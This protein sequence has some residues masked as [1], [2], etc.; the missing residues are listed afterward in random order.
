MFLN[1]DPPAR[2]VCIQFGTGPGIPI[3]GVGTIVLHVQS[4]LS[5]DIYTVHIQGAYYVPV[6]PMNILSVA[7]VL[8]IDG[9]AIFDSRDGPSHIRWHTESGDVRQ[10]M[11]WRR[12]LPYID[13]CFTSVE[14][15]SIRRVM[16]QGLGHDLVHS[17][18]GHMGLAKLKHLVAEGYLA[19]ANILAHE[20]FA[21]SACEAANAK[22]GPYPCQQDLAATQANHTLHTDLLH[23]PV[24][25]VDGMQY[26]LVVL[27]EYTRYA[28][29]AL[30]KRKSDAAVNL[31][32]IM[33]RGYVLHGLRVKH[34]R[35]DCGGEFQNTV[36]RIAKDE[37]GIA[38]QYVPANCHQ[39]NGLVERLNGT[40]GGSIRVV[41]EKAHLPPEMWGE[42]AVYAVH[43]YNLTPHS[44]LLER[45]A[46]SAIPHKLYI[47]DSADRMQRLYQQLVPFGICCSIIK[48][49]EKPAQVKKLDN[50]SVPGLIV[51]LGPST[52]QYRVLALNP[53]THYNVHIVRHVVINAQ[54]YAE[55][56]A[57][58][59]I[60]EAMKRYV[61][62]QTL[63]VLCAESVTHVVVP[64]NVTSTPLYGPCA[65]AMPTQALSR[66]SMCAEPEIKVIEEQNEEQEALDYEE[67]VTNEAYDSSINRAET[68]QGV[69]P[70]MQRLSL[71]DYA[72]LCELRRAWFKKATD[73]KVSFTE[74]AVHVNVVMQSDQVADAQSN[75]GEPGGLNSI[76]A[77][78]WHMQDVQLW[79]VDV[80]NPTFKQAINGPDKGRWIEAFEKELASL[81]ELDVYELVER[82]P[83]ANVMKGK[84]ICKIKR[85]A[86]GHIERFKCRYVGCGY[87]QQEGVDY[88]EHQ[89]WAPTGQHA[90]L[91]V[92][93]VHAAANMLQIRHIDISTAFLHGELNENV[94]VE[95]PPIMNDGSNRVWRLKKSLYGLKQAGRQWHLKL[96]ELLKRMGFNRAGYDPALFCGTSSSGEKQFIFLW[97]DDLIIVASTKAC[98]EVVEQ[99]LNT[100]KGR[101]LGEATWVLGMSITR[102]MAAK[103]IELSQERMIE[104]CVDRFGMQQQKSVWIPMDPTVE[105]CSDPHDKA[106]KRTERQCS[107]TNDRVETERLN[108]KLASF[109]KD[110]LP[111]S[112]AE[113][114]E[115]MS[116]IG[117]V[118]YVA[119]VTRPD[120]AFAASTLARFMSCPTNH[121]MNCAKR[122]LRYLNTTKDLV[123]RYDCSQ[124]SGNTG[125][126][127]YSD[128]DF[129]GC[130]KTSKS[131]SGIAILYRGQP[132]FW[133][134]KRQPIVTSSTTEAELVALNLCALQ[135]QWLK[136]L[137][138]SDLGVGP[139]QANMFCDNQST[140]TVA[141]NPVASDRSRHINVKHRKIQ[142]LIENQVLTVK[143]IP[144]QEQVADILTKQM[145][146]AQFE[147]LRSMLHVL[148]KKN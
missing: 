3:A 73:L 124:V 46:T 133:R 110:A 20:S 83:K 44:A 22:I 19:P 112:K 34:L 102:D 143:W 148:S 126:H 18:Y 29:V 81:N 65:N 55:Y 116:I 115:Y 77:E 37:L 135:V 48:T 62:V 70:D 21:C 84:V 12:K 96:S 5:R 28:F 32:R 50:R 69:E 94:Y 10:R 134:S 26:L 6:Q 15:H 31:L 63:N 86:L 58:S 131:T 27:D 125:I 35:A 90:T 114:S 41:L 119:V 68:I 4:M 61:R 13:C 111:L 52:R 66:G 113:H 85:D 128:A 24:A 60:L 82:P 54:H 87:S 98:D 139:M 16:P 145:P 79:A 95:Q 14:V 9:A 127:G 91:R 59:A 107:E 23:F 118:Q 122:L 99:V 76:V 39:S 132:V 56:F 33:K 36:M 42:A 120:I 140:V 106:R 25:T 142:E 80:D 47:K 43:L 104:N 100:F 2:D 147:H 64:A 121:L 7:D 108:K 40:L 30:L 88:F 11:L 138:G 123:L 92:L 103:T 97:V 1:I 101:D 129:A 17:T 89:V 78:L 57:R 53:S 49:G 117:S 144:T 67:Y 105:A 136:L 8:N 38:D 71:D 51:G 109:D 141:H 146:R 45:K 74:G 137:L 93:F 72:E 130:S 75:A